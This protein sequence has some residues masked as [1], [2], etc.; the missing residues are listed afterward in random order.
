M[1]E[2]FLFNNYSIIF[3][4][5][6]G[7]LY[8]CLY[9]KLP[10]KGFIVWISRS[11]FWFVFFIISASLSDP[12]PVVLLVWTS[13]CV[14]KCPRIITVLQA[15]KVS[16]P[17]G[18]SCFGRWILW[19]YTSLRSFPSSYPTFY[20]LYSQNLQVFPQPRTGNRDASLQVGLLLTSASAVGW[21]WEAGHWSSSY[22]E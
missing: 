17:A 10:S 6:S 21:T 20:R 19:Q 3:Y 9:K 12:S 7:I 8:H 11:V 16:S 18:N 2:R 15:T 1:L 14:R 13:G 4:A 5:G 22:S